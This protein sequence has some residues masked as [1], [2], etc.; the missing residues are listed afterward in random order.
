MRPAGAPAP[1]SPV[2]YRLLP[3]CG[4]GSSVIVPPPN[5]C[6]GRALS[7]RG[8]SRAACLPVGMHIRQELAREGVTQLTAEWDARP[9]RANVDAWMGRCPMHRGEESPDMRGEP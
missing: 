5:R 9:R 4:S 6:T 1:Q 7:P 2:D 8:L 3:L